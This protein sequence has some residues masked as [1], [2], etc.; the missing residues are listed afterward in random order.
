VAGA[1]HRPV[2][3]KRRFSLD[4]QDPANR[5]RSV[6][7]G[8]PQEVALAQAFKIFLF[9]LK[10]VSRRSDSTAR[11]RRATLWDNESSGASFPDRYNRNGARA[12]N[13]T[14]SDTML[15][16]ANYGQ[17]ELDRTRTN[18]HTLA[19]LFLA[20]DSSMERKCLVGT[21]SFER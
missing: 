5:I 18:S 12:S 1:P 17:I 13:G 6:Y 8:E 7:A 2:S 14:V 16:L 20:R 4:G 10:F 11:V 15:S 9:S 3:I 21:D 19:A